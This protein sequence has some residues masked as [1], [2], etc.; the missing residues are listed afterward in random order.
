MTTPESTS[1]SRF[2]I[3]T[4]ASRFTV[5]AFAGGMLSMLGHSPTFVVR[6]YSGE[7]TFDPDAPTT[8][9]IIVKVKAASLSLVDDVTQ[10]D[11]KTIER[12]MQEE[13]LEIARYPVIEYVADNVMVT[14]S[15]GEG[16]YQVAANGKLAL[17]GVTDILAIRARAT[18]AGDMLRAVGEFV[19]LQSAF[20]IKLVS[21]GGSMLRVKD[22]LRCAFDVVARR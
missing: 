12:T 3:D 18:L 13:V 14:R 11:R 19:I 5:R 15:T 10:S 4:G 1:T 16:A 8:A 21:I 20:G 22:E 9:S 6:E 2:V 17:H 7:V